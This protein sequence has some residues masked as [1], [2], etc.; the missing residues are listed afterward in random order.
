MNYI[1]ENTCKLALLAPTTKP[2]G[3]EN[4]TAK[5]YDLEPIKTP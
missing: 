1:E 2:I 5:Y 4:K 3:L